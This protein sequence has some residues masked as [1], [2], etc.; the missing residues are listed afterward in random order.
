[1]P[2]RPQFA[3]VREDPALEADLIERFGVQSAVLVASGGCT[4]LTL[5]QRF[6]DLRIAA[7]DGNPAQL[8]HCRRKQVETDLARLN[9]GTADPSGLNQCGAFEGLF[10]LLRQVL[11][12]FV[13][14]PEDIERFFEGERALSQAWTRHPYWS[15]AFELAFSDPLLLTMF[16]PAAIQHAAPGSYPGYF[17]AVFEQGL[18]RP[19]AHRNPFLQHVLLG[20]YRSADAPAYIGRVTRPIEWI[21]GDLLAAPTDAGLYALSNIFDWSDD[22]LVAQWAEHLKAHTRPGTIV[23]LRQ[24][25][26]TR[27]LRRFFAPHFAFDDGLGRRLLAADRSLFYN[28]IEVGIRG[29]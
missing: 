27:N 15:T 10:R 12:E 20:A 7:F 11:V 5:A 28:R 3:V 14:T 17:R 22:A 13:T 4:A 2:A 8:A 25:N 24:L 16:G 9:V 29:G 18:A 19:Q 1:M 26:N 23:L 21:Q 6:P